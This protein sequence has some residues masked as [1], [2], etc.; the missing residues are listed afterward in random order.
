MKAKSAFKDMPVWEI[1]TLLVQKELLIGYSKA[2]AVKDWLIKSKG[3][4]DEIG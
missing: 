4:N 3:K 1:K 2:C